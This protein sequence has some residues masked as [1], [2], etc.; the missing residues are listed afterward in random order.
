MH[1]RMVPVRP[2]RMPS[3]QTRPRQRAMSEASA[4][5]PFRA[6]L[7]QAADAGGFGTDDVLAA[8][9]PLFEQVAGAHETQRVAPLD[10][11]G[12]LRVTDTRLTLDPAAFRAPRKNL[13]RV[14][15]LQ[16]P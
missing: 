3:S 14:E 1:P 4:Q 15:A 12:D 10:G 16:K 5:A 13:A 8:V 9:L 6:F 11:I 7:K 2:P